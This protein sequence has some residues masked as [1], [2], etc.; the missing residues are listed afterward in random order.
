MV[1]IPDL[2]LRTAVAAGIERGEME[3]SIPEEREG[4]RGFN[5]GNRREA[6]GRIS[7]RETGGG[8]K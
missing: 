5:L 4:E 8:G 3:G 2:V 1:V 6:S 7:M